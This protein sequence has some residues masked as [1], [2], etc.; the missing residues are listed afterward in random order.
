MRFRI[1]SR[2]KV[3][4]RTLVVRSDRTLVRRKRADGEFDPSA[5]T[6]RV[7]AGLVA[8]R[9]LQ[10]FTEE[11]LHAIEDDRGLD[12]PHRDIEQLA[13]GIAALIVDSQ[14]LSAKADSL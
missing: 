13:L 7:Q 3:G 9:R 8:E 14:P 1:P 4:A 10:V 11:C 6:I 12:I 2:L 5:G